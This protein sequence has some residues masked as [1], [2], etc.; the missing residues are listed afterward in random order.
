MIDFLLAE[1]T[2]HALQAAW[3]FLSKGGIFMIPLALTALVG[4]VAI[5]YKFLALSSRRVI[6]DHLAR[7]LENIDATTIQ[8]IQTG[9][10]TLARLAAVVMRHS[11]KPQAEI[12]QAV[13]A[14][15]REEAAQLHSGIGIL[16]IVITVAPLLGLLGTA[17][18]LVT[19]FEG[20]G[21]ST[22]H[23]AV[24][25]GIAEALNTTIFGLTIAV[26]CVIA[27]GYFSRRIELISARLES[28]L[29]EL[30][31]RCQGV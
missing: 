3:E 5:F 22:D 25:R 10:S 9:Q 30:A 20:L 17:S 11:G 16:D 8:K 12:I 21:D 24:A 7:E 28:L 27:H 23:L 19:I 26:P 18:G 6:P 2:S 4:M 1:S 14:S 13:E 31:H 15:S 29:A